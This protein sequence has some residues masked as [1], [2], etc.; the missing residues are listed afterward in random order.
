MIHVLDW[1]KIIKETAR[2]TAKYA[3]FHRTPISLNEE[4]EYF[5]KKAYDVACIEI[6]FSEKD[7]MEAFTEA[8][9]NCTQRI[10]I[11]RDDNS[12]LS[13]FTYM[14]EKL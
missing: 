2:V 14:C 10:Q 4:T 9:L 6:H 8:G 13:H 7:V 5:M 1:K 3:M 12:K 11:F